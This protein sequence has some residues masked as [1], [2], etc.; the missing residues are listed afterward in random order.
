MAKNEQSRE[1]NQPVWFDGKSINEAL[2]CDDFLRIW[3]LPSPPLPLITIMR[4][5][6]LLGIRQ[7]PMNSCKVGMS[8]G[9][10]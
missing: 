10:Q 1:V 4:W 3:L 2:F 5:P 8:S 6:L 9:S 7:Y